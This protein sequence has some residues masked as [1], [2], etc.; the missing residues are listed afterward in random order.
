[1]IAPWDRGQVQH[2]GD[3]EDEGEASGAQGVEATDRETVDQDL[4][5]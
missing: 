3:A 1:M 4:E 5:G 2:A